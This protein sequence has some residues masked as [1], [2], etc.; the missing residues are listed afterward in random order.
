M[1]RHV[2][3][4]CCVSFKSVQHFKS[5]NIAI[6]I[7]F[8]TN[9]I[10]VLVIGLGLY[11]LSPQINSFTTVGIINFDIYYVNTASLLLRDLF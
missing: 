4:N 7:I 2:A 10:L 9:I 5:Y 8:F 1:C 3:V 6:Y 11:I